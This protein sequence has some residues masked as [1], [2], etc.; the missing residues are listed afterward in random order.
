[1]Q[2]WSRIDNERNSPIELIQHMLRGRRADAAKSI[3]ARRSQRRIECTNDFRKHRMRADSNSDRVE[4]GRDNFGN[5]FPPRQDNRERSGPELGDQ[6]LDQPA[7]I[8]VD[9]WR[10]VRAMTRSGR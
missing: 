10:R 6:F 5:D 8:I 9:P 7:R 3:R 2:G 4:T 1:M